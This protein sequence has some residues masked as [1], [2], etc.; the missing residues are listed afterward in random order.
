V[1]VS[2]LPQYHDMGLIGSYLGTLYC[3]GTGFYMSPFA[4]LKNPL[5][6]L[7]TVSKYRGTH[8]QAPSF[9]YALAARKYAA[10]KRPL[11]PA[12]EL[13]SIQHMIN[14]AEPVDA[15]ALEKFYATFGPFGLARGVVYPTYG[16]A[17][18]TVFVCS[19]G[20]QVLR[21]D[22]EAL[23]G[24]S[25]VRV[26]TG[27][28][29]PSETVMVGCGFPARERPAGVEPVEVAIVS[30]GDDGGSAASS[31]T[32]LGEDKVGEIWV[33]SASKAQGYWGMPDKSADDFGAT[34]IGG[35]TT[36]LRTGDLGFLHGGE[37]F[38]CG[39]L[40]DL[41]I[42]RGRNHYPQDIERCV[43]GASSLFRAGRSAAFAV[44]SGNEEQIAVVVELKAKQNRA[45][46]QSLVADI[47]ASLSKEQGVQIGVCYLC[48]D[49]TVPITTSGKIARSWCKRNY[50]AGTFETI[51]E[52]QD[53]ASGAAEEA[54]N[55]GSDGEL[56]DDDEAGVDQ[57][58]ISQADIDLLLQLP[59]EE[60]L[61]KLIEDTADV[62]ALPAESLREQ[63]GVALVTLGLDSLG[64]AQMKQMLELQ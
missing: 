17:E 39:R 43:E 56:A 19:G 58:P 20:T 50:D 62:V 28:E 9:A 11:S 49:H 63:T 1:C 10:L 30:V 38:I 60:L 6:W 47:R 23:E 57:E 53:D 29:A 55:G 18:H 8:L 22:K 59:D 27:A 33:R 44:S 51:Y 3:G 64:L 42:L 2:W 7:Q 35:S 4:F 16:L 26:C 31:S 45:T 34:L 61:A 15:Q 24:E 48:K 54:K 37:L 25:A 52:W 12:L 32:P 13:S 14:A 40:K 5:I 46:C 21:V 36:F 41:I